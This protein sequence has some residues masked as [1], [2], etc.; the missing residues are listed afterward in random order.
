MS[1]PTGAAEEAHVPLPF[2]RVT[3]QSVVDPVVNVTVP[4]GVGTPVALVVT[5]AEYVTEVPTVTGP[6]LAPTEV[7]DGS[8]LTT[9][10]LV[11]DEPAKTSSPEYAPEIVS[12]PAGAAEELQEPLPFDRVA[13]QSGVDPVVK[14]TVPVGVGTP[15]ALVVTVAE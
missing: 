15:V 3:T 13:T 2:D 4:V 1:V 14:V 5:V 10:E 11:P 9:R 7:C 8:L 6:G 12:V